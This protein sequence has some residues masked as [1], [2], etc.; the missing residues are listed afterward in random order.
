VIDVN[1]VLYGTTTNGGANNAGMV[2][3]VDAHT[4]AETVL[5]SFCSQAGCA[6]GSTPLAGVIDVN[7][8]LYGTTWIGG[9]QNEGT[10][11]S[12]TP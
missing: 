9:M 5:Y 6:D 12:V 7:G 1:G 8:A 3:S 11:F 2:F 4:G 10:V